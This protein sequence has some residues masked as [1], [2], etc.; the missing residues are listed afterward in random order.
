MT[1]CRK[2]N[3]NELITNHHC[4]CAEHYAEL[5]IQHQNTKNELIRNRLND[6]FYIADT[7]LFL[8][9]AKTLIPIEDSIDE[10]DEEDEDDDPKF[11]MDYHMHDLLFDK[12]YQ[13]NLSRTNLLV[14]EIK[15]LHLKCCEIEHGIQFIK[16][17]INNYQCYTNFLVQW[18]EGSK[19]IEKNNLIKEL[20][21][22]HDVQKMVQH[23]ITRL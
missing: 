8:E 18:I 21:M 11:W 12:Y 1:E 4:F 9:C 7:Q 17:E 5:L 10:D 13:Q 3:C 14:Q 20:D 22:V 16:Y 2:E 6:P 19:I 23:I 15:K